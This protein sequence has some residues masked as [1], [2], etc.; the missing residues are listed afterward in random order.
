MGGYNSGSVRRSARPL[1]SE[2]RAIDVRSF[3]SALTDRTMPP[4]AL[5]LFS[6]EE[7]D[8]FSLD[9]LEAATAM[10]PHHEL[11]LVVPLTTSVPRFGGLRYW[12]VC[13]TTSCRRRCSA[14]YREIDTNIRAFRCRTCV[15][16]RYDSQ[17]LGEAD[18]ILHRLLG[19]VSRLTILPT[20][21]IARPRYMRAVTFKRLK[22]RHD[23]L[24]VEYQRASPLHR[25]AAKAL[26]RLGSPD[27][28]FH[29]RPL[30]TPSHS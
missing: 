13:P 3:R 17:T 14:L 2:L 8:R 25:A 22:A 9:D 15:R 29:E 19:V 20:G 10:A 21:T 5:L 4:T 1:H 28:W 30:T 7:G 24:I 26:D 6:T 27:S 12:F 23:A 16:L 18:A 11:S